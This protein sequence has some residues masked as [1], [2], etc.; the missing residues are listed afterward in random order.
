MRIFTLNF[1]LRFKGLLQRL[2]REERAVTRRPLAPEVVQR[3]RDGLAAGLNPR[4]AAA[5]AGVSATFAYVLF[6]SMGG[7]C[8]PRVPYSD[9]FLS[10]EQREEIARLTET[11]WSQRRIAAKIG[12]NHSTVSRE[13]RRNAIPATGH[14]SPATADKMARERQRRPKPSKLSQNPVLHAR[15]QEMADQDCSPEQ[16]SGRLTVDYPDDPSMRISHESIYKSIYIY[17]RGELKREL[18]VTLRTRRLSRRPQ[19]RR[20]QRGQITGMVSIHD[21]PPE[22]EGR[23]VPGHHEGDLIKGSAASGSAV[24]TIVERTTGYLTLIHLPHGHGAD[25]V[26]DAVITRLAEHPEWFAKT[27]TWDRGKEMSRHQRITDTTPVQVYFADPYS[28]W[29]RGTNENTN[30]LLR[31]YL[32]KGTD[33]SAH[34]AGALQA[35]EDKLNNRPRKRLGFRTPREELDKLLEEHQLTQ[36]VATTPRIRPL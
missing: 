4:R 2:F 18:Q 14:Y 34:D 13:L 27:L 16:I 9:R 36:G 3:V 29:Q 15:V 21:R 10:R 33:L 5:A 35:I 28:P 22:A 20:D 12:V 31:Q 19:G 25:A 23:R 26:A 30:G 6:R 32:P 1:Q 17:P 11:G 7:V 8:K 24:A